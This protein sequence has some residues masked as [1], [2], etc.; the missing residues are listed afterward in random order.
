MYTPQNLIV[1]IRCYAGTLSGMGAANRNP[2]SDVEEDYATLATV[3]GAFAQSFDTQ[4]A[5]S[6]GTDDPNSYQATAIEEICEAAWH[7]R[8][9]SGPGDF[10]DPTT[11]DTLSDA[12]IAIIGAGGDYIEDQGITPP[13]GEG[14][15]QGVW[16]ASQNQDDQAQGVEYRDT[17]GD[18]FL[19]VTDTF[20]TPPSDSEL[21]RN[22]EGVTEGDLL[23]ITFTCPFVLDIDGETPPFTQQLLLAVGVNLSTDADPAANPQWHLL[24]QSSV[25]M[26]RHFLAGDQ[27][28]AD[29]L[30]ATWYWKTAGLQGLTTLPFTVIGAIDSGAAGIIQIGNGGEEPWRFAIEKIAPACI[31]GDFPDTE[32]LDVQADIITTPVFAPA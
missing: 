13:S 5:G 9:P 2:T 26:E 21:I 16:A 12:L 14:C 22:V 27:P 20:S 19:L 25:A 4:W 7:N 17:S 15:L 18:P 10:N 28:Q 23:K 30:E 3:A 29:F 6:I 24:V 8:L 31:Q 11:Y 1:F 32:L